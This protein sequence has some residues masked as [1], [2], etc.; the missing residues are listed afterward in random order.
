MKHLLTAVQVILAVSIGVIYL[1][2]ILYCLSVGHW[3]LWPTN[4]MLTTDAFAAGM[5]WIFQKVVYPFLA[6]WV[7]CGLDELKKEVK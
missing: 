7:I 6:L 3:M 2:L 5:A 4:E 1:D